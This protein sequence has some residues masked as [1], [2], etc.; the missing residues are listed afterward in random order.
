MR[1]TGTP[2]PD[3]RS[4]VLHS[5]D[6]YLLPTLERGG[7]LVAELR[8]FERRTLPDTRIEIPLR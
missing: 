8:D 7:P 1:G 4:A 5:M 3:A 2:Y 6:N